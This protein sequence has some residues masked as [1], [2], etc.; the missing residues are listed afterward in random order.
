L[1]IL[2]AG[3]DGQVG[4]ALV[5]TANKRG[6]ELVALSRQELDITNAS[7][8]ELAIAQHNP[9]VVI[10]AAAYTAVDKAEEDREQAHS[11]NTLGPELLAKACDAVSVP[12]LHIST[13]FVFDGEKESAYLETDTCNPLG[14]YG[15][16]KLAG[17]NAINQL[18]PRH[19]ILRT[20][21]VFGG[22]QNFVNTMRRLAKDRDHLNVVNDQRGG[23]TAATQIAE[24]LL[25]IA[26]KVVNPA[27]DNWG[28]YHFSGAPAVSWYEFA[29]EILKDVPSVTVTAIPTSQYP[30]PAKRPANSVLDCKKIE[31]AFSIK[32]PSWKVALTQ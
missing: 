21:W 5:R 12:F 26:E 24:A 14:V 29:C 9:D 2:V 8:V 20:S 32:Q 28:I 25:I 10:N 30:T 23:P 22:E 31:T 4:Q 27:F 7:D 17:E 18:C 19:I 16:S 11:I 6:L 1:K 3:R 13:D 15:A